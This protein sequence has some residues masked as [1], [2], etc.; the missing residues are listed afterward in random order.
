MV[1]KKI[2]LKSCKG[3]DARCDA[4]NPHNGWRNIYCEEHEGFTI[5]EED[6]KRGFPEW[7]PLEDN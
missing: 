4:S 1:E 2:V 7:C 5:T 6:D 3:C